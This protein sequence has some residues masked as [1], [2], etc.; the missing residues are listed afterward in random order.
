MEGQNE[1]LDIGGRLRT[2]LELRGESLTRFAE[3]SGVPYRTLQ[4]HVAGKIKPSAEQLARFADAGIDLNFLLTGKRFRFKS[5]IPDN[6]DYPEEAY[7][8][9]SD[10]E[11]TKAIEEKAREI[12]EEFLKS[13]FIVGQ[14]VSF[15]DLLDQYGNYIRHLAGAL[16][17][18]QSIFADAKKHGMSVEGVAQ[19][20]MAISLERLAEEVR[21]RVEPPG[22]SVGRR[23]ARKPKG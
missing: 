14:A 8:M 17:K 18:A 22:K 21:V 2:L 1:G 19:T 15:Q 9:F 10:P 7:Y 11:I 16:L 12:V 20:I 3:R 6:T 5:A 23:A 13:S 4:N